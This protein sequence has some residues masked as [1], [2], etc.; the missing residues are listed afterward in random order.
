[1]R[2]IGAAVGVGLVARDAVRV[3]D[4]RAFLALADVAAEFRRLAVGHPDRCG[5]A[6]LGGGSPQREDVDAGVRLAV[7]TQRSR[8]ASG[9]VLGIPG[10][11]PWSHAGFEGGDN[12][13]RDAGV[14]VLPWR[15]VVVVDGAGFHGVLL[16][17]S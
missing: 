17:R 1:M 4:G 2:D 12:L 14:D 15:L 16:F 8:D 7:V 10:P 5:E 11:D 3:N 13:A 9:G 6:L